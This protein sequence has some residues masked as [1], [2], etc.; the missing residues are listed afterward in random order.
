MKKLLAVLL[1]MA[2]L[3]P[4]GLSVPAKAEEVQ[5]KPFYVSSWTDHDETKYPYLNGFVTA[6]WS[7][8]GEN[9]H[10]GYNG[11]SMVNGSYTDA[12]VT[13]LAT[14]LMKDLVPRPEGSRVIHFFGPAK[15]LRVAPENA[16]FMDFHVNQMAEIIDALMKKMKEMNCPLDGVV[17]DTEYFGMSTY[18]LID[19][20]SDFPNY[21]ENP[22]LLQQIVKDKRYKELIRPMLEDY[23]FIFY[24]AGDPAKQEAYTELF[25]ITKSAGSKY[26][27]SR[28]IWNVVMRNHLNRYADQWLYEPLKKYYPDVHCYDYQ[29]HDSKSWLKVEAV[30][31]DGTIMTGGNGNRVGNTSTYSYYYTRPS[32]AVLKN[33][34]KVAGFNDAYFA[35]EPFTGLLYDINFTRYL[36]ESS[37][38]KRFSPW[39][40]SYNYAYSGDKRVST[41]LTPYYTDLIYHIG[42]FNPQPFLHYNTRAEVGGDEEWDNIGYI[43]NDIITSLNNLAGYSDR[44]PISLPINWNS[45]FVLTGMYVNGRNL[46]RITPNTSIISRGDFLVSEVD[47]GEDPSFYING[48]TITFPGGK[49]LEEATI[50]NAKGEEI[51]S[52]GYWV[53]TAKDVTPIVT[54]EEGRYENFPSFQDDFEAYAYGAFDYNTAQPANAWGFTWSTTASGMKGASTVINIDN[55]KMVS[56]SGNTKI[57]IKELPSKITAG[58]SFAEDQAW[59]LTVTIPEG[60]SN[61]AQI[62]ILNYSGSK[63]ELTDGGFMVTGGK[64]YYASDVNDE[65]GMPVYQEL[66]DVE[67]DTTYTFKRLMNFNDKDAFTCT[68]VV[69]SKNGKT[70]KKVEDVP[71]ST[72]ENIETIGFSVSE[73]DKAV[74]VDEFKIYLTGATTDFYLYDA[75]TGRD[76]ELGALRDRSTAYRLSWLNAT[77]EE[78]TVTIKADITEGGKTTTSVI[79]EIKMMPGTDS[80]TTGVVD[81]K[82]GQTVKVYMESSLKPIA[83][84][85]VAG[86]LVDA[87]FNE[88]LSEKIPTALKNVG[89]DTV[90]KIKEALEGKLKEASTDSVEAFAHYEIKV[91]KN[92]IP[93][94]G[95]MTVI[96]PYPEGT[97]AGY[98]FYG[99]QLHKADAYGKKAGDV[100]TLKVI[101]TAEGIQFEVF[102]ISPI[103]I[104]WAAPVEVE[105]TEAPTVTRTPNQL[106]RPVGTRIT[107]PTEAPEIEETEEPTEETEYIEETQEPTEETLAPTETT[108]PVVIE[109]EGGVN[110]V[111]IIVIAVV[112]LAGAG[113]AVFFLLK[114]KKA[115]AAAE[116]IEE[117]E[118]PEATEEKTEE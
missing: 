105:A 3:V 29:S 39:I 28:S 2:M 103:T 96:M 45:K 75:E 38:T 53:E 83:S 43:L 79:K 117:I 54:S 73:A 11:A 48:E 77:E 72:F 89:L 52:V 95:K 10:L 97:D 100:E 21:Q 94:D 24:D 91:N 6:S 87:T 74:I 37:D 116:E 81:I 7:S 9:A 110:I 113:A 71:V 84:D 46:W 109:E 63:Q 98:T 57:W 1:V 4:M 61:D 99:A 30:T 14:A 19:T 118:E 56:M 82:E 78:E 8:R 102:G 23:G 41:A 22:K 47:P 80:I 68:Y 58:D 20:N 34:G 66:M 101:N 111:L 76:A 104:G 36:Y 13:A 12:D 88:G 90:D 67:S 32:A 59:E 50:K 5:K 44:E 86:P 42:M 26:E 17:I 114:K 108:A 25:S 64:L 40:A 65:D 62:N 49:I 51:G 106:E 31:D 70:L 112:V 55:N 107:R 69:L 15:L 16:L 85:D 27:I 115:P 33:L 35:T 18:Y 92:D 60:L 93:R